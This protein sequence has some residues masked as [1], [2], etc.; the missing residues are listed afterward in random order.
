MD[1]KDPERFILH[2][3]VVGFHHQRGSEIE[4]SYPPLGNSKDTT[5]PREWQFLPF[6][7]LPDGAHNCEQDSSFFHLPSL[8]TDITI[9]ASPSTVFGVSCFKQMD[10]KELKIKTDDIT[11]STVQKSVCVLSCLPLYGYLKEKIQVATRVYF[12]EKDFARTEILE[13]LYKSLNVPIS[14]GL[15]EESFL[16]V[17]LSVNE[18]VTKF[19]HKILVLFKLLLLE[20]KVLFYG[21]PVGSLCA[22]LVSLVSLFP[23]MIQS[24]LAYAVPPRESKVDKS[25]NAVFHPLHVTECGEE[26]SEDVFGFP[27][28]IFTKNSIFHPYLCLQQMD[29]LKSPSVRSFVVGASNYLFKRQK[30]LSDVLVD[31]QNGAVEIH[32]PQLD[33]QLS[34]S[35]A[36]LRFADYLIHHVNDYV[37]KGEQ[38]AGWDGSE[39]WI[40][41]Q[42]KMYLLSLLSTIQHT[43]G[44]GM[45]NYNEQFVEA[46]KQTTNFRVWQEKEH[47]GIDDVHAGHPFQGHLGLSDIKIRLANVVQD[48]A[49]KSERGRR[50]EQAVSQTSMVVGS[51]I[52]SARSFVTSWLTANTQPHS[53]ELAETNKEEEIEEDKKDT[54]TLDDIQSSKKS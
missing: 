23:K 5:L 41:A 47:A 51:A 29:L 43:D 13:E 37:E 33:E 25:Q 28:A 40:R 34:L 4:F 17:G 2:I 12:D 19:R 24:G 44:E 3:C 49:S 50:I 16:C 48:V 18:L 14:A 39:E 31:L 54:S 20:R 11:R 45:T 10:S 32:D 38:E 30:G 1:F 53:E 42:F 21:F 7:A 36:D 9:N 8:S 35:T 22:Q 15:M 52:N 46:W 6:L 27:L 26:L